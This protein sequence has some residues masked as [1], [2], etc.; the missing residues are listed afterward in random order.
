MPIRHCIFHESPKQEVKLFA[1]TFITL[2]LTFT[3]CEEHV[4][5]MD[6]VYT[7]VRQGPQLR[8]ASQFIRTAAQQALQ[9]RPHF[10]LKLMISILCS[11]SGIT[12]YLITPKDYL[13]YICS[14]KV[15]LN[16]TNKEKY[17]YRH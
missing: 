5:Y 14:M 15:Q 4:L 2:L 12:K 1:G 10:S 16:D 11:H 6:I 13:A 8:P 9:C 17:P 7:G 3:A